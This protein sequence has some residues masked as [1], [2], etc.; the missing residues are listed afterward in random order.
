MHAWLVPALL[1]ALPACTTAASPTAAHATSAKAEVGKAAPDFTLTG[2]D[3]STV[4]LSAL[5]D[6]VVVL[7]WFNPDCPFVVAAHEPGGPLHTLGNT[8][9]ARDGVTWLAIN[10]GAAGKQGAG[11]QCN[12]AAAAAWS[13]SHP[14]LLDE[15]GDVGRAYGAKTTP[16]MYVI[17]GAG[18][19]RYAGGLDDAP[20]NKAPEGGTTPYLAKALQAVVDGQD[21]TQPATKPYG[22]SVKY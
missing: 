6:Q 17:D 14:V 1:L 12:A 3:G 22:C 9:H 10:S 19:L 16:H 8:W 15:T 21:V 5:R 13:L 18:V 4:A 7:E 11:Q 2:V 20:L